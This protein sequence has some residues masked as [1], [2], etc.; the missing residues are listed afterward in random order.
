MKCPDIKRSLMY[1]VDNEV[2]QEERTEIDKH[3]HHC[4][5]CQLLL[6]AIEE[7]VQAL[8]ESLAAPPLPEHFTDHVLEQLEPYGVSKDTSKAV[9]STPLRKRT[10]LG[11][12][13]P[14]MTVAAAFFIAIFAGT[15]FSPTFAA[16]VSSFLTRLGGDLGLKMAAQSGFSTAVNTSVTDGGVTFK[17]KDILA[18]PTR[19]VVSY[20]LEDA[21]GKV[22]PDLYIPIFGDNHIYVTDEYG[23]KIADKPRF[24]RGGNYADFM[25]DL[26]NPPNNIVVHFEVTQYGSLHPIP[27]NWRLEVPVDIRKSMEA[28]QTIPISQDFMTPQGLMVHVK[29]VTYAPSATRLDM[30][31]AWT[32][33]K[34]NE[35]RK[36]VADL[37]KTNDEETMQ[38]FFE[39]RISY[40]IE[41]EKGEIYAD[42]KNGP[43]NPTRTIHLSEY[44][45]K[46]DKNNRKGWFGSFV[47]AEHSEKL[48]LV[49]D[50]IQV[51]EPSSFSIRFHP[52]DVHKKPVRADFHG[53]NYTITQV[54][55]TT[56]PQTQEKVWSIDL[57]VVGKNSEW[58]RWVLRDDNGNIYRAEIDYENSPMD[59]EKIKERLLVKGIKEMPRYVTLLLQAERKYY[60]NVKWRIS[61]PKD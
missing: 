7:E 45:V 43:N 20:V 25:F 18:D 15:S 3:L 49:L 12:R 17:V 41:N 37:F 40:H 54:T 31:T 47:P 27:V 23:K 8:K 51:N 9:P 4:P 5:E 56:D 6:D 28:T 2:T 26:E 57:E 53:T 16:Y 14:M 50:E 10:K 34:R 42:M 38:Y 55:E 35:I 11:W 48:F 59:G 52:N 33:D 61:I 60:S 32:P 44:E 13:K 29:Q 19:L 22:L 39:H 21:E 24:Q 30:E 46:E 1:Y 36:K 58:P